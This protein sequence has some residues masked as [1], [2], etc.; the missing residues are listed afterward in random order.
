MALAT[1]Y[2]K[3]PPVEWEG[4]QYGKVVTDGDPLSV[5]DFS[6]KV[7]Y[8]YPKQMEVAKT[9]IKISEDMTLNVMTYR[10]W[11]HVSKSYIFLNS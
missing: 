9:T 8:S 2:P 11:R 6:G 4:D 7:Y 10:D 5:A 1:N 3:C